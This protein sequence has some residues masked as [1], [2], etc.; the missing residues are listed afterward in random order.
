[1]KNFRIALLCGTA[2]VASATSASADSQL[3][4]ADGMTV[5]YNGTKTSLG[6]LAAVLY[7]IAAAQAK[8]ASTVG[9]TIGTAAGTAYDGAAGLGATTLAKGAGQVA[10]SNTWTGVNLFSKPMTSTGLDQIVQITNTAIAGS[11]TNG[12]ATSQQGLAITVAKAG[13]YAGG[14]QPGQTEGLRITSRQGGGTSTASADT[15]G[16]TV[17]VQARTD[18]VGFTNALETVVSLVTPGTG[19]AA[20]VIPRS[21]DTQMGVINPATSFYGGFVATLQAG[22][23]GDAYRAQSLTGASWT[24]FFDGL[25]AS[26]ATA[27]TISGADGSYNT[28]TGNVSAPAGTVSGKLGVFSGGL[29]VSGGVTHHSASN[30]TDVVYQLTGKGA[31]AGAAPVGSIYHRTDGGASTAFYVKE[32]GTGTTGWV[33]YGASSSSSGTPGA[34][35]T[36][37]IGTVSTLAAG[38]AATVTNSGSSSAAVFNIGIPQ[39]AAGVNGTGSASTLVT[40]LRNSGYLGSLGVNMEMQNTDGSWFNY[41]TTGYGSFASLTAKFEYELNYIGIKR[42]RQGAQKGRTDFWPI[43]NSLYTD[44]GVTINI[45]ADI[46]AVTTNGVTQNQVDVQDDIVAMNTLL[47]GVVASYEGPNEYNYAT[48]ILTWNGVSTSSYNNFKF[49]ALVDQYDA[50][51]IHANP[52]TSMVPIVDASQVNGTIGQNA[53][54]SIEYNNWHTYAGLGTQLGPNLDQSMLL[55]T[56]AA[57]KKQVLITEY[58]STNFDPTKDS[59]GFAD[60]GSQLAQ[61]ITNVGASFTIFQAGNAGFM[62][63]LMDNYSTEADREGSFGLFD[64]AGNPKTVAFALHNITTILADTGT[65]ALQG[66]LTPIPLTVTGLGPTQRWMLLEDSKGTYSV[67]IWDPTVSLVDPT[68]NTPTTEVGY[69]VTVSF[70]FTASTVNLYYPIGQ[71]AASSS[72][73]NISSLVVGVGQAPAILQFKQ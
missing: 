9:L 4:P 20:D 44:L 30:T 49:G 35:A 73:T 11:G 51:M 62:Y 23:G 37:A 33:A 39:G 46:N 43:E 40:P 56:Y 50:Y 55:A 27:F 48:D 24:N 38:S 3:G 10:G 67:V 21:I 69:Q 41:N 36:I 31:P 26:G 63:A 70:G 7:G 57:A 12:P 54:P 53:V 2:I 47:P 32:S 25:L 19:G 42:V 66:K 64:G 14:A 34:A 59:G 65:G 22:T 6:N 17:N 18:N 68:T 29:T 71:L 8:L 5:L 13:W 28:P 72:P 1:M 61:A 45:L 16:I 52:Q 15:S 58:G 60:M